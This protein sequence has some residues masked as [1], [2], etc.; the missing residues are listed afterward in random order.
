[1]SETLAVNCQLKERVE[2]LR[3]E[4]N[5]FVRTLRGV[6]DKDSALSADVRVLS[7]V[8]STALDDRSKVRARLDR[9]QHEYRLEARYF[10]RQLGRAMAQL[11]DL[12]TKGRRLEADAEA[13]A[14]ADRRT[15]YV[16]LRAWRD[17]ETRQELRS[18]AQLDRIAWFER[19]ARAL[20]DIVRVPL[21]HGQGAAEIVRHFQVEE[22]RAT[23]LWRRL[24]EAQADM[25]AL[26]AEVAKLREAEASLLARAGGADDAGLGMAPGTTGTGLSFAEVCRAAA[27]ARWGKGKTHPLRSRPPG[28]APPRAS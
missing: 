1:M 28:P 22:T 11:V 12:N 15:H 8:V 7:G 19:Q 9:L 14:D 4:R 23:S 20:E 5:I 25:T 2:H 6:R 3:K 18:G 13:A 16:R 17:A 10:E 24:E 21:R 27:G 26:E